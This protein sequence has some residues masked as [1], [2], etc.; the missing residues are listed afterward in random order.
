MLIGAHRPV[1]LDSMSV[2]SLLLCI[3]FIKFLLILLG[4]KKC[5]C[6]V[7][8]ISPYI[9][10]LLNLYINCLPYILTSNY[11]ALAL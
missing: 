5:K 1:F 11:V 4:R 10:I 9:F 2:V 6:K 8:L 3:V 7:G